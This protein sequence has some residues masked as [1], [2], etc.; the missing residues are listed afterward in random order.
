M[1]VAKYM[2]KHKIMQYAVN[3]KLKD[4]IEMRFNIYKIVSRLQCR[5]DSTVRQ[6]MCSNTCIRFED[7]HFVYI[8]G[9]RTCKPYSRVR[10]SIKM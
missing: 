3:A 5:G 7:M 9:H 4:F 6:A 10:T 2:Y 8:R 1:L